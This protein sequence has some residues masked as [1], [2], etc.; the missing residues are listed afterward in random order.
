MFGLGALHKFSAWDKVQC[1]LNNL[2]LFVLYRIAMPTVVAVEQ[3]GCI[4]SPT[5]PCRV[6]WWK[7][8]L[9]G[10]LMP[11]LTDAQVHSRSKQ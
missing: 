3:G 7:V 1:I 2:F 10:L 9:L 6:V 11:H 5:Y 4:L 8:D